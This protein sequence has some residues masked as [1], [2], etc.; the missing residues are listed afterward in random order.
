M[1]QQSLLAA[2][3]Q[4]R[5][6]LETDDRSDAELLQAF[7]ESQDTA[8]FTTIV[9]RYR[10]IVLGQ[11]RRVLG[12]EHDAEDACQATFLVLVRQARRL[13]RGEAL[14]AW[15]HGTARHIAL[16]ARRAAARRRAHE[17]KAEQAA[18]GDPVTELSWREV[19][20]VLDEEVQRLPVIYRGAFILCCLE[21][22]THAE[23]GRRLGITEGAASVR[24]MRARQCLRQRLAR[25]G[26]ALSSALTAL[27]VAAP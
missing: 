4:F 27:A 1:S 21:G 10:G 26:I 24:L 25:R 19:R 17:G 5:A 13:R 22:M 23:A 7:A 11:C 2:L 12:N 9:R 6:G 14:A 8:A 3:H 18:A 15:L 20:E 16:Q